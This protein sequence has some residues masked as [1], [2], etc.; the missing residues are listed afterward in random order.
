MPP[1]ATPMPGIMMLGFCHRL[2]ALVF[3]LVVLAALPTAVL[4][5]PYEDALSRFVTDDFDDTTQAITGVA[6]S[7]HPLA[8][9]VLEALG[10]ERLVFSAQAKTVFFRDN[11]DQL[12][13][14]ATGRPVA[15]GALTDLTQVQ[16]NNRLRRV[17]EA[18]LGAL[19]L[20][21]GAPEKRL[22]AA[23]AVFQ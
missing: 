12:I 5:G 10:N 2:P 8:A 4:A 17:I 21:A 7:G 19:T 23:Q 3:A 14:A 1:P 11:S 15:G 22:E 13:D 6:A 9:A 20:M 16:I 18:A